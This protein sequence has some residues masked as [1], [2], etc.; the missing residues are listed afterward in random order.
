MY[1]YITH[2][3]ISLNLSIIHAFEIYIKWIYSFIYL[4]EYCYF[5]SKQSIL[6]FLLL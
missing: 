1:V 2:T 6:F 4:D 3:R 5:K